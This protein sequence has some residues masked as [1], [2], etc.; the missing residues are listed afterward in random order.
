MTILELLK[1]N[2]PSNYILRIIENLETL[3]YLHEEARTLELDLMDLFNWSE[4]REGFEFWSNV[5]EA[6]RSDEQLPPIPIIVDWRPN[7]YFSAPEGDYI[8]NYNNTNQ[9]ALFQVDFT[10]KPKDI[11]SKVFSEKHFACCN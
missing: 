1:R 2:L 10:E 5:Y 6:I 11:S 4:S 8:I 3:D 7:T 9:D